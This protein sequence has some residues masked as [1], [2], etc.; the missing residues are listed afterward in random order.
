MAALTSPRHEHEVKLSHTSSV[1]DVKSDKRKQVLLQSALSRFVDQQRELHQVKEQ[2]QAK[3]DSESKVKGQ[4]YDSGRDNI[5]PVADIRPS[6]SV[7]LLSPQ[8]PPKQVHSSNV[9]PETSPVSVSRRRSTSLPPAAHNTQKKKKK[10]EPPKNLIHK[11]ISR[12]LVLS[13]DE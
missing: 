8:S 13:A 4:S 6:S 9:T 10:E 11:P 1:T 3:R 5:P 7:L 12:S 2:E